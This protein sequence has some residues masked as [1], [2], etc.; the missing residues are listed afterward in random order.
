[1]MYRLP[2][3]SLV[4]CPNCVHQFR[5]IP[6]DV[7]AQLAAAEAKAQKWKQIAEYQ[8]AKRMYPGNLELGQGALDAYAK[9]CTT[10]DALATQSERKPDERSGERR[11]WPNGMYLDRC[12]ITGAGNSPSRRTATTDRRQTV[13][14]IED[15]R[16]K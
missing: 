6:E 4:I 13:G 8:Y 1:M 14:T 15:R 2:D 11:V 9:K 7:Q 10:Y 3:P 5:A 16:V 12:L